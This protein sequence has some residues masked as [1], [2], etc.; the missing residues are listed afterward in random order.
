MQSTIQL[1]QGDMFA[2]PTDLI[3]IPCSTG[4]TITRSIADQLQE[5]DIE[6]PSGYSNL[7]DVKFELFKGASNIATYVGY[8]T[9]VQ[10]MET[11]TRTITKIAATVAEFVSDRVEIRDIAIPLLG[12]GAGCLQPAESLSALMAGFEKHPIEGKVVN[13]FVYGKKDFEELSRHQEPSRRHQEHSRRKPLREDK[14]SEEAARE[15]LRVFISYTKTSIEHQAWVKELA[16]FL[17][18]NGVDARLDIWHLR[19][20]MDLPQW[21]CN[22]LDLADRVLIV[23]NEEYAARAN[24]RLGGVG[25]EMRVI[26]G[27]LLQSQSSN[28]KKYLPI[29]RGKFD[30]KIVP[31]FLRGVYA[32]TWSARDDREIKEQLL[33]EIYEVFDEAPILGQPPRFILTR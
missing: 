14:R 13:I 2:Q 16:I 19:P 22:E 26:Q 21:M 33:R 12:A 18:Q 5:F 27:D 7:G 20:G 23:C 9:S 29:L 32:L 8:A 28:P 25:W 31:S 6:W 10:A 30:K 17:R 3:I 24:G 1:R 11:N 4:G 15:P